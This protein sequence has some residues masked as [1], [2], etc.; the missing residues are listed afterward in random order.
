MAKV[1]ITIDDTNPA[2]VEAFGKN[3]L[4]V[5]A[6]RDFGYMEMVEKTPDELP[7]KIAVQKED[8][9]TGEKIT[10]MEYPKGTE[11]YK[12][13]PDSKAVHVGKQ[14]LKTKIVPALL[15]GMRKNEVEKLHQEVEIKMSGAAT[16]LENV[17]EITT[18]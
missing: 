2:I 3:I 9:A 18:Q 12:P 17:A 1:T 14:M 11:F 13:N 5:I 6:E 15:E 16:L 7:E 4:D 8:L 10:V